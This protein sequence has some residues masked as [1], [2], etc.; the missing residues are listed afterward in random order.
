MNDREIDPTIQKLENQ[1]SKQLLKNSLDAARGTKQ[2]IKA[3]RYQLANGDCADPGKTARDL[4]DVQAKSVDKKL[5][6]ESRPSRITANRSV[7]EIL[8]QLQAMKV[9]DIESTAEE[10]KE[11]E[12]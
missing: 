4:A 8:N 9:F 5:A 6:L 3:A 1:L 7:K 10:V 2:A 12:R 11:L